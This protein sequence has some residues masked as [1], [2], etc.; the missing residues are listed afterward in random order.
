MS[1]EIKKA[2]IG[3]E[4]NIPVNRTFLLSMV[5]VNRT[6]LYVCAER[7]EQNI[8][9]ITSYTFYVVFILRHIECVLIHYAV[10]NGREG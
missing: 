6:Q 7:K 1:I 4:E 2:K 8:L 9:Y 5:P 10:E 3:S